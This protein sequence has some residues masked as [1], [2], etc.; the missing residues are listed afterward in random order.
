MNRPV[1]PL[2]VPQTGR[3]FEDREPLEG[4]AGANGSSIFLR[5]KGLV[6]NRFRR[7][8]IGH[9]AFPAQRALRLTNLPPVCD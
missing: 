1:F 8:Q 3:R 6:K 4:L 9:W 7:A 2:Y 5:L